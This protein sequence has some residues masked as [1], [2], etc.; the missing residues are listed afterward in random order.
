M[1]RPIAHQ[2]QLHLSNPTIGPSNPSSLQRQRT[3]PLP[4]EKAAWISG[5]ARVT[6]DNVGEF[7]R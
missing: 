6:K 2:G 4:R 1:Q 3:N 7:V 5:K